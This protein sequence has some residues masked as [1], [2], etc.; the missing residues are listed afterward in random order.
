MAWHPL[1]LRGLSMLGPLQPTAYLEFETRLNVIAGASETGKSFIVELI[2]FLLGSGRPLRDI[3]AREGYDEGRLSFQTDTAEDFTLRRA[4]VGGHL[5]LLNRLQIEGQWP[6][7]AE[8]LRQDGPTLAHESVSR[9]LLSKIGLQD[10]LLQKDRFNETKN[11]SFRDLAKITIVNE[12]EIIREGSP[13][14]SGELVWATSELSL[15]KLLLTGVD[16]SAMRVAAMQA[17]RERTR[18]AATRDNELKAQVYQDLISDLETEIGDQNA[19]PYRIQE[20]RQEIEGELAI[21]QEGFD[22]L[23][24][25]LSEKTAERKQL[26]DKLSNII[27]RRDEIDG[28]LGRFSLLDHHYEIDLER[29]AHIENSGSLFLQLDQQT[30]PLCGSAPE[31]QRHAQGSD[32]HTEAVVLAAG[33]EKEKVRLLREELHSTIADLKDERSEIDETATNISSALDTLKGQIDEAFAPF[34]LAKNSFESLIQQRNDLLNLEERMARLDVLIARRNELEEV[35]ENDR[36]ALVQN[37]DQGAAVVDLGVGVRDAFAGKVRDILQAW[38]FPDSDRVYFDGGSND[39]V[40]GGQARGS[41]G[42][43]LRAITHAA[44]TIG[45]MEFCHERNLAHP[46]FVVLDSPLLAYYKP[47]G[48]EDEQLAGSDLKER[49]YSYLSDNW[50]H[51]Q[52]IVVENEHPPADVIPRINFVDFT[53]N[54]DEGRYGFFPVRA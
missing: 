39:L 45:L 29:L 48:D 40:I 44:V 15:F 27:N 26:S 42:K 19:E 50:N 46:G 7:Q 2:N 53:K 1:T 47:E 38:N 4:A 8:T 10:K 25:D 16:A 36:G 41:R 3:R 22:S 32:S 28:L 43:G 37:R 33:S 51:G 20:R 13:I 23:K 9:F 11:L 52:V 31:H 54:P 35:N 12:S 5:G 14:L 34:K 17:E 18:A 24:T 49:F 30:C 6:A 21:I